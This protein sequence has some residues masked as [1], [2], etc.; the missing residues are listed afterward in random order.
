MTI[1][2]VVENVTP[3]R[4]GEPPAPEIYWPQLQAPR[5]A[6]YLLI[7]T[8]TDPTSLI[9]P[10]RD[11][12]KGLDPDMQVAGFMTMDGHMGRQLVRPRF[13]MLLVGIF[14]SVA[15]ILASIGIYGVVSYSVAMR[16]R[17]MGIRMALGA[18]GLDIIRSVVGGGLAPTALGVVIGLVGAFGVTRLLASML[19]G[20]AP[21]DAL[22]FATIPALLV[23]VAAFACFLPA[24]RAARVEASVTLREE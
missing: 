8:A 17:E 20:V 22:T 19:V 16:S 15:L 21:T 1:V 13:N 23:L 5:L 12:L 2:G 9:G 10:I 7:R 4:T 6:T 3:F 11:R 24:R 14:A 18:R